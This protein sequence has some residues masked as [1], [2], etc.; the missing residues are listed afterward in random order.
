M[1]ILKSIS[2]DNGNFQVTIELEGKKN[3]IRLSAEYAKTLYEQIKNQAELEIKNALAES[4][5]ITEK[6]KEA[7]RHLQINGGEK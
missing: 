4:K 2:Y 7:E 3:S 1:T 6:K 5:R